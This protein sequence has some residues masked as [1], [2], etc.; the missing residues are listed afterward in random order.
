[1]EEA[2]SRE[3]WA[4]AS[5]MTANMMNM[6]RMDDGD[7]IKPSDLNPWATIDDVAANGTLQPMTVGELIRRNIPKSKRLKRT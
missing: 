1:M 7:P 6:L 4:I 5:V 2:K 3:Q